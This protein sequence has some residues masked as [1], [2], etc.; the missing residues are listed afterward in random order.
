MPT[1]LHRI[2]L[3]K[4]DDLIARLAG[5]RAIIDHPGEKGEATELDWRSTI[6]SFLPERYQVSKASVIDADGRSSDVIDVVIHDRHYCPLFFE[7]G[8]SRYI[9]AESVYAI[10]EIKQELNKRHIEYA[11]DKAES[12]R[13]LRR[14]SAQIVERGHQKAPRP[15]FRVLSGILTLESGWSSS[16]GHPLTEALVATTDSGR[17]DL[18]CALRD[19]AFEAAYGDDGTVQLGTSEPGAALMFFFLRLFA[20]LQGLGTVS[21]IDLA[22][23]GRV[24][25][26]DR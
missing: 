4:Q 13:S 1:D 9:P 24:L 17:L 14:T 10:F 7:Y 2:L 8:G 5:S 23:Y 26:A 3:A 22:E 16:L 6:Q 21:A 15:L 20:R 11:A 12:V 25:E 19:G 18:G